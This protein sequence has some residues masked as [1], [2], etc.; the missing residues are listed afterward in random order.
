MLANAQQ[1][2]DERVLASDYDLSEATTEL[3]R[4]EKEQQD[5]ERASKAFKKAEAEYAIAK[6]QW[7]EA[8]KKGDA[9]SIET[10]QIEKD[11]AEEKLDSL[12]SNEIKEL[13][14]ARENRIATMYASS[15]KNVDKTTQSAQMEIDKAQKAV[16]DAN[17]KLN[18][19][20][21]KIDIERQIRAELRG[22]TNKVER[23]IESG[24]KVIESGGKL[25]EKVTK[26]LGGGK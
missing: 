12:R 8:K 2:L 19:I 7:K 17:R 22:T 4:I 13:K 16:D 3:E 5:L 24:E 21:E 10:A 26:P 20:E 23:V 11:A 6:Q 15:K 25:I 18:E 1:Q 9:T 14:K